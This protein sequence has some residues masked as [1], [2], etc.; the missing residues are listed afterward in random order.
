MRP[1]TDQHHAHSGLERLCQMFRDCVAENNR[2]PRERKKRD[3]VAK[4]PRQ[5]V[6]DNVSNI[7]SAG[8]DTGN[9]GDVIGLQ[10]VLHPQHKTKPQN[11][12]HSTALS[13][14]G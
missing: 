10:R 3:G 4:A 12:K 1:Q 11:S 13:F 9:G 6:P 5:S 7:G 2:R 14:N 8:R